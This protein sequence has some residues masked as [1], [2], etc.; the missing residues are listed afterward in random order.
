MQKVEWWH[1]YK[2]VYIIPLKDWFILIY[3]FVCMSEVPWRAEC[4]TLILLPRCDYNM[5]EISEECPSA[6]WLILYCN[7]GWSFTCT[8]LCEKWR[9]SMDFILFTYFTGSLCSS[10]PFHA[11]C[12]Y[13]ELC[14][15]VSHL[16]VTW[17][18]LILLDYT[19]PL[20]RCCLFR[21]STLCSW[22]GALLMLNSTSHLIRT[23]L[24]QI[25]CCKSTSL[26][27]LRILFRSEYLAA[28]CQ[29]MFA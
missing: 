10:K 18:Y 2:P 11:G 17:C 22:F 23:G 19:S 9:V 14:Q 7:F 6:P 16:I 21:N 26:E 8:S 13:H 29:I 12:M 1:W 25:T 4:S 15:S 20:C 3:R 28:W 27:S 24:Y 5:V